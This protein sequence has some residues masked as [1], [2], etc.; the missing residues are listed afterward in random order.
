MN[1][2]IERFLDES[3]PETPCLVV[4][5][6]AIAEA[7]ADLTRL[8]PLARVYYAVKA[9]PEP[10]VVSRLIGLGSSFD[11]ASLA[12]VDLCLGLGAG[13]ERLSFGNTIKKERDIAAAFERGVGLYAFDSAAELDKIDPKLGANPLIN[14]PKETLDKLKAWAPLSVEQT[15]EFNKAYATVTGG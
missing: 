8:L 6:D 11:A 7:Y 14:P 5:L 10:A 4:D 3:Q 15:Q 1:R 12:E 2:K 13:P 9:N